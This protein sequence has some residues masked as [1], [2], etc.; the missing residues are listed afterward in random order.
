LG[1]LS[2]KILEVTDVLSAA[3]FDYLFVETVGVGQSEVDIAGLAE[4]TVVVLVPEAGDEIQTM[5]AGLMEI[6]DIF[7]VNK[8]DR[9]QA[10]AFLKNL[11]RLAHGRNKD[12][13]DTPV[14]ACQ[15]A[16]HVGISELVSAIDRLKNNHD[17]D[18]EIKSYYLSQKAWQLISNQKMEAI[19][20]SMLQDKIQQ[21]L[22][23]GSFSLYRLVRT[24][25]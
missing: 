1:G 14:F 2:P 4:T 6:A 15:A 11:Q 9:P 5:K 19:S 22:K 18:M 23:E 20:F 21:E 16:H 7:V 8:S 24:Y 3:G 10:A 17:K 25:R 13:S 12:K